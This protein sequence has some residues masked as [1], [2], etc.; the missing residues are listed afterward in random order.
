MSPGFTR[1]LEGVFRRLKKSQM[2]RIGSPKS[3]S[4]MPKISTAVNGLRGLLRS[5]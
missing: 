3:T 4:S 2:Y 1:S 5:G